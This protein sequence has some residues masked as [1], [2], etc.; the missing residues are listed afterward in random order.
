MDSDL[1]ETLADIQASCKYDIVDQM[2]QVQNHYQLCDLKSVE[3]ARN[4][5]CLRRLSRKRRRGAYEEEDED[6]WFLTTLGRGCTNG[7]Y[8]YVAVSYPWKPAVST[9]VCDTATGSTTVSSNCDSA[10]AGGWKIH[11]L[12]NPR[13]VERSKVRDGVL[14][15]A[16]AYAESHGIELVWIDRECVPQDE[17]ERPHL[18]ETAMQSMDLV[19][20][21]AKH[22]IALIFEGAW[23]Q[24][25]V[26][27]LERLLRGQIVEVSSFDGDYTAPPSDGEKRGTKN[28]S[29]EAIEKEV[30]PLTD[31]PRFHPGTDPSL[32]TQILSLLT[33]L[34]S[35]PWFS[36]AWI[37]Q[38]N[39]CAGAKMRLLIPH[40]R[41]I[42][43]AHAVDLFGTIPHELN[44]RS[45]AFFNAA[46]KFCLAY[47]ADPRYTHSAGGAAACEAIIHRAGRYNLL[48]R[49]GFVS[50]TGSTSPTEIRIQA[51][52]EKQQQRRRRH[53]R[54]HKSQKKHA[55]SRPFSRAMSTTI[56]ADL[57]ARR[58]TQPHDI[59]AIAANCC[60]Y[61]VRLDTK[62]LRSASTVAKAAEMLAGLSGETKNS[63]KRRR[64][65]D[66]VYE[67]LSAAVLALWF[68][69]GEV[70]KN[71]LPPP[72]EPL[73]PEQYP[74][75]TISTVDAKGMTGAEDGDHGR[76][77]TIKSPQREADESKN[78]DFDISDAPLSLKL[79]TKLSPLSPSSASASASA[80][81]TIPPITPPPAQ[82]TALSFLSTTTLDSF[83][84]PPPSSSAFR[85][86]PLTFLKSCRFRD[87]QLC[88]A[89]VGTHGHMWVLDERIA[90]SEWN[91]PVAQ[92]NAGG[93]WWRRRRNRVDPLAMLAGEVRKRGEEAGGNGRH[94]Q[95]KVPVQGGRY[96]WLAARLDAMVAV[97]AEARQKS[98]EKRER[99]RRAKQM[100]VSVR[101]LN[102][103]GT[104]GRKNNA[105]SPATAVG[106]RG[107]G[108][109]W[110]K[111]K[112]DEAALGRLRASVT[113]FDRC[114]ADAV[115]EAI[116]DGRD[117][118]LAR[119]WD[120]EEN[121]SAEHHG[122]DEEQGDRRK[123]K[124]IYRG[125]FIWDESPQGGNGAAAMSESSSD[126]EDARD[127][128]ENGEKGL[129]A[130]EQRTLDPKAKQ[131]EEE[132]EEEEAAADWSD[133]QDSDSDSESDTPLILSRRL[134]TTKPKSQLPSRTKAR[135]NN[136]NTTETRPSSSSSSSSSSSTLS[137][138]SPSPNSPNSSETDNVT[139][140]RR[141][142]AAPFKPTLAF[143]SHTPHNT[144]YRFDRRA[145]LEESR[146]DK[147]V[148]LE[149][150]LDHV[151]PPPAS[152]LSADANKAEKETGIHPRRGSAA[153]RRSSAKS[154]RSVSGSESTRR[155]RSSQVAATDAAP[156]P[157]VLRTKRWING[158]GFLPSHSPV[159]LKSF[160]EPCCAN[161]AAT[162]PRR[163]TAS[164]SKVAKANAGSKTKP[165][166]A[167]AVVGKKTKTK[168]TTKAK[169]TASQSRGSGSGTWTKARMRSRAKASSKA[170][171]AGAADDGDKDEDEASGDD[172]DDDDDEGEEWK[173][174]DVD[175][176]TSERRVVFA[177]PEG[178]LRR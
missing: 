8:D 178:L 62:A 17:E 175:C 85:A 97:R 153:R 100:G 147:F 49:Y 174:A 83:I 13:A 120:G 163:A 71:M 20:R 40:S 130:P 109:N 5:S 151:D 135:H 36:R 31:Y 155:R 157:P 4:L 78:N 121:S 124:K 123:A 159:T 14:S 99:R 167:R 15:R 32:I 146:I 11:M 140:T 114:M 173:E 43:K 117:L 166:K 165:T 33:R 162:A 106:I 119:L 68:L 177:W 96:C 105:Y 60:A 79:S 138:S 110:T 50:S 74:D 2:I 10:K 55:S 81:T 161:S 164:R 90:S 115:A 82:G 48:H 22:P 38:E 56:F 76:D 66:S 172:D 84:P 145:A 63:G 111:P 77:D 113:T 122:D 26:D 129:T 125:V 94:G 134:S 41:N 127:T 73:P 35:D 45:I 58:I 37:F 137:S 92:S 51:E 160:C 93:K 156:A 128:G 89:G 72:P 54:G 168:T 46:T 101:V 112:L 1:W 21:W 141:K 59:L 107:K 39:Y 149:V 24:G 52:A 87:V 136:T 176:A 98:E 88:R 142:A 61:D 67:S 171:D 80:S 170:A 103:R 95:G 42:S 70:F 34:T 139:E 25:E 126:G 23:S 148:S 108:K 19:Y 152:S 12:G 44:I 29:K 27:L 9:A 116:R 86:G 65:I 53:H 18:H 7:N 30:D 118:I 131:E 143:T 104:N 3:W 144:R 75:I 133:V 150:A 6:E 57:A 64:S 158:L 91:G 154:S 102:L 169:V 69:N 132:E 16:V 28:K 47:L